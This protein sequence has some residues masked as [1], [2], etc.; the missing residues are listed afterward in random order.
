[1]D[2]SVQDDV[3]AAKAQIFFQKAILALR[4][5]N[6]TG[7]VKVAG[8]ITHYV[9]DVAVFGHV[10]GSGTDWGA[11]HHHSDYEDYVNERTN[12]FTDEFNSYLSFDGSLETVTAY[13]ATLFL[14]LDTTFDPS[15]GLTAVWMDTNYDWSNPTFRNRAGASLN[16]AV[17]LVADVLH[18]V[19]VS[20]LQPLSGR[21]VINEVEQN[22]PGTDTG[23][24]WV[25]LF[26]QNPSPVDVGGWSLSTTAGA[27][28]SVTLPQ[29]TN[30]P[31]QGYF[32]YTHL[33]QWLDNE[34]ESVVLSDSNANIADTSP[35]L[36]DTL[37]D[38]RSWQRFPNGHDTGSSGDWAFRLSTR[39]TSNGYPPVNVFRQYWGTFYYPWYCDGECDLPYT[40]SH[41]GESPPDF[42]SHNPP[43]TW[44]SMY[45]PD[46][47]SDTF[48]PKSQLYSSL[49]PAL[50]DRHL[51]W[52]D[53]A[54]LDFALVSWWGRGA[55]SRDQGFS[56]RAFASLLREASAKQSLNVALAA[57]YELE[58]DSSDPTPEEIVNDLI[59][60]H[61]SRANF[62]SYFK[63]SDGTR[64]YPVVF[65]FGNSSVDTMD[66]TARWSKAR[67]MMYDMGKP[68]YISLKVWRLDDT[69]NY[70][71]PLYAGR[72]DSWHQYGPCIGSRYELQDGYSAYAS[73]GYFEYPELTSYRGTNRPC[74]FL[75][76]NSD[77]FASAVRN[78]AS[79]SLGEARFLLVQTFNEWHEGSQIEPGIPIEHLELG[80][81]QKAPSYG[82]TYLDIVRNRGNR[83]PVLTLPDIQPVN[84]ESTLI[85]IATATDPDPAQ[86]LTFSLTEAPVGTSINPTTGVFTWTPT[87]T[88]GP[89]IFTVTVA[90]RDNGSPELSDSRTIVVAV[91]EVNRPPS[92]IVPGSKAVA[93]GNTLTFSVIAEDPDVP[94]NT[95]I[96]S[97]S[98]LAAEMQFDAA[99]GTFTFTPVA[100]QA[101][102]T[103]TVSFT[104]TDDG[105]PT[106]AGTKTV[107]ITVGQRPT[108]SVAPDRTITPVGE[109]V[110]LTITASDPDGTIKTVGVN[111]GDG[112]V[113][114]FSQSV[115]TVTHRYG[116]RGTYT[117]TVTVIDDSG[118]AT[119]TTSPLTITENISPPS[120][121]PVEWIVAIGV[122][123]AGALLA[124]ARYRR[125]S[126]RRRARQ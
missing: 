57:Y 74:T 36:Y 113:E 48:D 2:R 42:P 59:F 75:E 67:D 70:R 91:N 61:D 94:P 54:R 29:G 43:A 58:G 37:N 53:Y 4:S 21:V 55:T 83:Q 31:S 80:F 82:L 73:P 124:T 112:A 26:N 87:E 62:S 49:S 126:R 9:D 103:F 32:V 6:L 69:V 102:Q 50:L 66:Y 44:S 100:S 8:I 92:L 65:V 105:T 52:M 95:V 117:V 115:L 28:V 104:A 97:T 13:E 123:A 20:T 38:D 33:T 14:A 63:V 12:A 119:T 16:L 3:S 101:G 17:N 118:L 39:E 121:W 23:Y 98:G 30:I 64:Q 85:M 76:R 79:L 114:T 107:G 116:G 71:N 5:G 72:I 19:Y 15:G 60:I 81:T 109:P 120:G 11:E 1:M 88:Q 108:V 78:L 45:L 7:A 35:L 27:T 89:G 34:G 99:T 110:T 122:L 51:T 111:W 84:E 22:P 86:T 47:G 56:D 90:V 96:L 24:E 77:L 40:W 125:N 68:V 25:E 46:D 10:M 106:L 93:I 41:W 18:T